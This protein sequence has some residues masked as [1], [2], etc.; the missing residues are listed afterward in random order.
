MATVDI[1]VAF[2]D[3]ALVGLRARVEQ[4]DR[5]LA[6]E[7]PWHVRIYIARAVRGSRHTVCLFLR[8]QSAHESLH[9]REVL[10]RPEP[11]GRAVSSSGHLPVDR[12]LCFVRGIERVLPLF[13]HDLEQ[14][15]A[16]LF[17]IEGPE[18]AD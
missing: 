9:A 3:G 14:G 8:L 11:R 10:L 12:P 5:V 17:P 7:D 6:L 15:V 1:E 4:P 16:A 18:P 2:R 13:E